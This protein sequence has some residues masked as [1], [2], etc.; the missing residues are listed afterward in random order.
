M[1]F[2]GLIETFRRPREEVKSPY[3]V[4]A[5]PLENPR[6]VKL[7]EGLYLVSGSEL[8]HPWDANGMLLVHG[9]QKVLIDPGSIEGLPNLE[10]NLRSLGVK[11]SDITMII[12]T[13][14]HWDHLSS[15]GRIKQASGAELYLHGGDKRAV[16][17]GDRQRTAAFLYDRDGVPVH[18]DHRL[19][20]GQV[21]DVGPHRIRVLH[22]PGHTPGSVSLEISSAGRKLMFLGD[23][24]TGSVSKRIGSNER[25][26]AESLRKLIAEEPDTLIMGHAPPREIKDAIGHLREGLDQFERGYRDPWF[27]G[28]RKYAY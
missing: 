19:K 26:W 12:A 2:G 3:A 8:T 23:T 16:E 24:M 4:D 14:G 11:L 15:V 28:M 21:F 18:V 1:R 17:R 13:H 7:G 20:D 22:T 5:Q 10:K 9:D 6:A 27:K 25:K